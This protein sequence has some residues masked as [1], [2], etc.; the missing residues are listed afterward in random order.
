MVFC[1]VLSGS[2]ASGISELEKYF[3]TEKDRPVEILLS[4]RVNHLPQF[5]DERTESLNRLLSH[6]AFRI[7]T[8][9]TRMNISIEADG[10]CGPSLFQTR[11][12]GQMIRYYSCDSEYAY[13]YPID[14]SDGDADFGS[15]LASVDQYEKMLVF[16]REF[17]TLF[18]T[19]AGL[20]DEDSGISKVQIRFKDYGTAVKRRTLSLS[21][22]FLQDEKAASIQQQA[23]A[24]GIGEY[25][26]CLVFSGR[27]RFTFLSDENDGLMKVNYTGKAGISTDSIRSVNLEWKCLRGDCSLK[28]VITLTSPSVQGSD[29]DNYQVERIWAWQP[30]QP[31]TL[32]IKAEQ[33]RVRERVRTRTQ[34]VL[35]LRSDEGNTS[36]SLTETIMT[37]GTK[38]ITSAQIAISRTDD[39]EYNGT[40]EIE[41][42][43]GKIEK[44]HFSLQFAVSYTEPLED[45]DVLPVLDA[46]TQS[47]AALK[48][49]LAA[50]LLPLLISLPEEDLDYLLKDLPDSFT[51]QLTD[52]G[53][54]YEV[55]QA[56]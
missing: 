47:T 20:Y 10:T 1:F 53:Q 43:L 48:Q 33:D 41:T 12:H 35:N 18:S 11:N 24:S 23:N 52:N 30:D 25:L 54:K 17:Y 49:K 45:P 9:G 6:L 42:E 2:F 39:E 16:I 31:E 26:S 37:G 32:E 50:E 15:A 51:D 29:R 36:G 56:S 38:S 4:V 21:E 44:D 7:R 46:D 19:M 8:D 3:L 55:N 40:L 27:Q 5:S 34:L 13:A 22:H 28:D 14:G